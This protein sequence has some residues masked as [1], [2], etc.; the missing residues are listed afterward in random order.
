MVRRGRL[1]YPDRWARDRLSRSRKQELKVA[2]DVGGSTCPGSG[3]S[4]SA[5]GDVKSK[6]LLIECKRTDKD[7]LTLKASVLSKIQLEAIA[8]GKMA[9]LSVEIRDLFFFFQ[10]EDGIR[11]V[12]V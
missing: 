11:D 5:K 1:L 3:S 12:I 8:E 10:A 4:W 7:S 6:E 9:V 2:K